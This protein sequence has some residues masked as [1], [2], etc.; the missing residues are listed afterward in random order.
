MACFTVPLAEAAVVTAVYF[1]LRYK[2]KKDE[3]KRLLNVEKSGNSVDEQPQKREGFASKLLPLIYL[4][5]GGSVLLALEHLW[6]GEIVPY[7]PFLTA[8][9][10]GKDAVSQMLYEMATVGVTMAAVCTIAWGAALLVKKFV[11][12]RKAVEEKK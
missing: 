7:F 3:K 11:G 12:K 10:Q 6:H 1:G 8:I 9:D 5:V 4:L 2:E